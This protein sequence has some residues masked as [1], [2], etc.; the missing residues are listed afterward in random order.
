MR[1]RSHRHTHMARHPDLGRHDI[2]MTELTE[3]T[4]KREPQ[5]SPR[6]RARSASVRHDVPTVTPA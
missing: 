2:D 3:R 4:P 1:E 6:S 5:Q